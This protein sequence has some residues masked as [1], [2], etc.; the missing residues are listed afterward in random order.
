MKHAPALIAPLALL[1]LTA[2]GGGGSPAENTADQL[3]AAADQSSEPAADVLDN[4]AD[5]IE[6]GDVADPNLAAEQALNEAANAQMGAS[7]PEVTQPIDNT[8]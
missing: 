3:E 1:A 2:C 6:E 8:Q 4:A 7:P 5:R